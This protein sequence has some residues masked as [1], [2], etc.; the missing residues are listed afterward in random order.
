LSYGPAG[1]TLFCTGALRHF[2]NPTNP[3]FGGL[4]SLQFYA[5]V[6]GA[7]LDGVRLSVI[8]SQTLPITSVSYF[9]GAAL[10]GV[11]TEPGPKAGSSL[12]RLPHAASTA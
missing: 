10:L 6:N 7:A 5:Y 3:S 12:T 8:E 2:R 1:G 9:D 4:Q 11:Q